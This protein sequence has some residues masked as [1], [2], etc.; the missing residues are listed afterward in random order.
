MCT[1]R[2]GDWTFNCT[3]PIALVLIKINVYGKGQYYYNNCSFK[4]RLHAV[5][6]Q[7]CKM[8]IIHCLVTP[9]AYLQALQVYL[10]APQVYLQAPQVYL[11]ALQ[12]YLRAPQVYLQAPQVYFQ[13]LQVAL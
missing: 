7:K 5:L 12:V 8:F 2:E 3:N 9:Q 10:Q 6:A 11:R 1:W 13:A 4:N